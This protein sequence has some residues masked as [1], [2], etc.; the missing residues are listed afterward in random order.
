MCKFFSTLFLFAFSLVF[1]ENTGTQEKAF[2]S[3]TGKV[4]GYKVRL[5]TKPDLE[6][7]IIAK[8]N[9]SDLLLVVG[10]EEDF[11]KV[12]PLPETKAYVFRSYILDGKIEANRVN[13][14]LSPTT[15]APIIG[16]L[17]RGDVID[18]EISKLDHKWLEIAP[19]K[20]TVFYIAKEFVGYAGTKTYITTMNRKKSEVK[21]LLNTAYLMVEKE[22]KK[23]F[24]QMHSEK[25]ISLFEKIIEEYAEFDEF[26]VQAKEGLTLLKDNYLQKKI[27][28]LE[29]K[30][31]I[32]GVAEVVETPKP[33]IKKD[34]PSPKMESWKDVETSLFQ[35]WTAFHPNKSM[36]DFYAEQKI[37]AI[38]LTG[39]VRRF[40][41]DIKNKPGNYV[42][43][44][45][46]SPIGYLYSTM[47]DL[48]KY[49]DK[50]ITVNVSPR[51]NHHFAFPAYFVIESTQ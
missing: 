29:K 46:D 47:V 1:S 28:F 24:D 35:K 44:G 41:H 10:Q 32:P 36:D 37:G 17:K 39:I 34:T 43:E 22:C 45:T 30:A 2:K 8:L 13:I 33:F 6:S 5:R 23:P 19:P 11:W 20:S 49:A 9:K 21:D 14:R 26:V 40:N 27:A 18:G 15:D 25:A 31:A 7:H 42:L 38:K 12:A 16:Q 51:S 48:E 50:K 4:L 3:F